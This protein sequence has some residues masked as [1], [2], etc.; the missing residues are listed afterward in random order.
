MVIANCD[1]LQILK[2]TKICLF[3]KLKSN[4]DGLER[5]SE[6]EQ[7]S[8]ITEHCLWIYTFQGQE[9]GQ[10]VGQLLIGTLG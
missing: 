5:E 7:R 3:L 4:E 6:N 9:V 8:Q 10:N 2:S 1:L